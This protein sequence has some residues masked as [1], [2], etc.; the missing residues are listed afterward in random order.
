MSSDI[1]ERILKHNSNHK[2]GFTNQSNDW[3]LVYSESFETKTD[4][5]KR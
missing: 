4:A 1:Q 3:E 2:K 5:I